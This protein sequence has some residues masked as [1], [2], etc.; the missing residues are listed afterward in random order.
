MVNIHFPGAGAYGTWDVSA[1]SALPPWLVFVG[2]ALL[3]LVVGRF[4]NVVIHRLPLMMERSEANYIASL[5]NEP[6]PYPAPYDL[7]VPRSHCPHCHLPVAPW[8]NVPVI[9]FLLLRGRC[10]ACRAPIGWRYLAVELT[11]AA[12]A[13]A[14]LWLLGTTWQALAGMV[15]GW[16]LLAL[17]LIDA[18]SLVLPDQMTQPLLWLGL[19]LNVCDFFVPAKDAII[20]A[21]GGYLMLWGG[22]WLFKLL[23][24][25]EGMGYGDFKLM[26]ALGAWF[27]WQALPAL[28]LI[29]S[30]CGLACA[31]A[32]VLLGRL[33]R[34][35]PFPFGPSIA[36]AGMLVLLCGSDWLLQ[37][38]AAF[39]ARLW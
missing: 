7:A 37:G 16:S 27:G 1:L 8:H 32:F 38:M 19:F 26:A 35:A 2:A 30:L 22:Y 24:R 9:G 23:R 39:A 31:L 25:K 11:G 13:M 20:G 36:V 21:A 33:D 5:R 28:L 3:G 12:V 14:A 17:A 15:L 29:S 4:F 18:E 34:D 6:L 10:R